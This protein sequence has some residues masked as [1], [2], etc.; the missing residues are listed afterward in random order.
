MKLTR[1]ILAL[2]L[3]LM[4]N[5]VFANCSSL[6]DFEAQKL[7]SSESINFC[8]NYEDKVLLVVNTAS[9]CGFTS[10]FKG[11]EAL[12]Q[13]YKDQGLEIVG[14][15]SNDFFQ[16]ASNESK[17]A[18]VCYIN[19]GVTFTMVSP[20]A[21]RGSDANPLF[22]QLAQKTGSAPSWN[23]NKYLVNRDGQQVRHY[24]SL[25]KPLGSSLEK[26]ILQSLKM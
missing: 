14:F 2:P 4:A 15:P 5:S 11:L 3:L 20:S 13:K 23:F 9:H 22:R 7:R 8:S 25:V 1:L 17:T 12:Y 26:D 21:V 24:G 18:E 6:L 16:E 10:Q 19:Y